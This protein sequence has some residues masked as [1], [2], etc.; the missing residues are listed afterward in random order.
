MNDDF[1][2]VV[3]VSEDKKS[4]KAHKNILSACSPVIR[5]LITFDKK[6]NA[7]IYL[8]GIDS[9]ELDS[10]MHFIYF[11][12]ATIYEERIKE[13]L[14]VANSLEIKGLGK[15]DTETDKSNFKATESGNK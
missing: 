14:R 1:S 13:F 15:A 8:K 7:I 11:G 3:L 4:M 6:S 9:S 2:D 12:E 10:I 5:D